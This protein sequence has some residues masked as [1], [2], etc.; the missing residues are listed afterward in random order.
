MTTP[1]SCSTRMMVVLRSFLMSMMK[2]DNVFFFFDVH[3]RHGLVQQQQFGIQG[4]G[5]GHFHAFLDAV[6][7][8]PTVLLR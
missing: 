6:A 1:R 4:Q 8:L 2:A 3:S 5:P 7:R